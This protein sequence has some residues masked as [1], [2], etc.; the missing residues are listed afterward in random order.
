LKDLLFEPFQ[1]NKVLK[2]Q[3]SLISL[4]A[5]NVSVSFKLPDKPHTAPQTQECIHTLSCHFMSLSW[6]V[7]NPLHLVAFPSVTPA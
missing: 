1:V 7:S 2:Y 5:G 6:L 4:P 3:F